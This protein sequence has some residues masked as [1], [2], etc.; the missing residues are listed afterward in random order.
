ML[1]R[2][3]FTDKIWQMSRLERPFLVSSDSSGLLGTPETWRRVWEPA[4]EKS[5]FKGFEMIGWGGK[6]EAWT[7]Y[8]IDQAEIN[9]CNIVGIHGR[10]G[11]EHTPHPISNFKALLGNNLIIDTQS[12]TRDYGDKFEYI[13]FHAPELENP[14]GF[15]VVSKHGADIKQI[16]VENHLSIGSLGKAI[17]IAERLKHKDINAGVMFDLFHYFNASDQALPIEKRWKNLMHQVRRVTEATQNKQDITLGFHVPIGTNLID[18]FP[19][20]VSN[21]MWQDFSD[22]LNQYPEIMIVFENR[23]LGIDQLLLS[24]N[25]A[26]KQSQHNRMILEKFSEIKLI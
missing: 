8:L 18:S 23:Q 25:A 5:N 16:F 15:E 20:E 17:E 12:L 6:L 21:H 9:G 3:N 11:N 19:P 7:K 1:T 24:P 14:R 22:I 10:I 26:R 4:F 13:L 2:V